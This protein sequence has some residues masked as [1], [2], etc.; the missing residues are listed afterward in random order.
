MVWT[1]QLEV[2]SIKCENARDIQTFRYSHDHRVYK[3]YFG[4]GILTEKLRGAGV[5]FL[6][7]NFES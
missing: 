2:A 4:I 7:R 3:I 1:D 5:I 6:M